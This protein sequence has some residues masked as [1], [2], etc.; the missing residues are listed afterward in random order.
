MIRISITPS[1]FDN[2]SLKG[3]EYLLSFIVQSRGFSTPGFESVL[4]IF[5]FIVMTF[6][7]KKQRRKKTFNILNGEDD[8]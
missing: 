4:V 7:V 2:E 6:I 8:T 1:Y 3:E 5:A